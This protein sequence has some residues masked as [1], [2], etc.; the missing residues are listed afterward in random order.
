MLRDYSGCDPLYAAVLHSGRYRQGLS[1]VMLVVAPTM[2]SESHQ[3]DSD[4]RHL[5]AGGDSKFGFIC[6]GITM[7]CVTVPII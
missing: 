6:D 3:H 2:S 7:W 5:A 4:L 1:P